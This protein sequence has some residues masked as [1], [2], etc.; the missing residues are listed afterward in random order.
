MHPQLLRVYSSLSRSK[1]NDIE[2]SDAEFL[3][4]YF[5]FAAD[6][7]FEICTTVTS[8]VFFRSMRTCHRQTLHGPRMLPAG[9]LLSYS[10]VS[11]QNIQF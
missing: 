5:V 3:N 10:V 6:V 2:Y 8:A 7:L 1:W 4:L 11:C 9:L